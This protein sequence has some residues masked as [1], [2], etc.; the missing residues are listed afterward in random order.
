M[1][2][3]NGIIQIK[4]CNLRQTNLL[5]EIGWKI[6]ETRIEP[7]YTT[8]IGIIHNK[9]VQTGTQAYFIMGCPKRI[10]PMNKNCWD[11]YDN[12]HKEMTEKNK[13]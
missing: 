12:Y 4:K 6:L 7:I 1:T 2:L 13:T 11:N 3:Y 8:Q 5:L 9:Y 10:K